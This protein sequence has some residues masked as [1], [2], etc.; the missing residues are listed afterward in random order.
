MVILSIPTTWSQSTVGATLESG[1]PQLC[2]SI[3]ATVWFRFTVPSSGL[4]T[5]D[6]FGSNYDTVLAAYPVGSN[7]ALVCNDDSG[8]TWQWQIAFNVNAGQA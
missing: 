1:E 4:V 6:T 2:G 8:G 7:T 5:V 3:G